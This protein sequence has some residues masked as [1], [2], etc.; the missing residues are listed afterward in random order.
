MKICIQERMSLE[1]LEYI[2]MVHDASCIKFI[3][4]IWMDE[5]GVNQ[6]LVLK[7]SNEEERSVF[8]KLKIAENP[9]KQQF[10]LSLKVSVMLLHI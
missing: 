7:H 1:K 9:Y 2:C 6:D 3:S 8:S 4:D 10:P 5:N